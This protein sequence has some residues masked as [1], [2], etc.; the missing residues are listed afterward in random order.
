MGVMPGT[1]GLGIGA[2]LG[3]WA[4][5]MSA[6]MLPSMTPVV[7]QLQLYDALVSGK[8]ARKAL[9]AVQIEWDDGAGAQ[10]KSTEQMVAA[11]IGNGGRLMRPHLVEKLID[12][13]KKVSA[14]LGINLA[15]DGES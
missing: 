4:L 1:M 6:M 2:F 8:L 9:D 7:T 10:W 12:L 11:A 5:M 3:V 15:T 14:I 13:Q